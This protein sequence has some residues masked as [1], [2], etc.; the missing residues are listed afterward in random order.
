M[1]TDLSFKLV[2]AIVIAGVVLAIAGPAQASHASAT[3]AT[4]AVAR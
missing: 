4:T 1:K 2:A 3:P